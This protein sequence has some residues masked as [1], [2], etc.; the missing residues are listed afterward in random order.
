MIIHNFNMF[1]IVTTKNVLA[2][3]QVVWSL[4]VIVN[5]FQY[6]ITSNGS[7]GVITW[8]LIAFSGLFLF[9]ITHCPFHWKLW[10]IFLVF[11][12]KILF[13]CVDQLRMSVQVNLD[14]TLFEIKEIQ[15]LTVP[16]KLI[17]QHIFQ[18]SF[19]NFQ[20]ILSVWIENFVDWNVTFALL[21]GSTLNT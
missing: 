3:P 17:W 9:V 14:Y 5:W 19:T 12:L 18:V 21:L 10:G 2:N 8:R 1:E 6:P 13:K 16:V 7:I 4:L 11:Q 15:N 20:N